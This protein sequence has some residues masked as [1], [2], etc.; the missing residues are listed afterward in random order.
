MEELCSGHAV[1]SSAP[2]VENLSC[3]HVKHYG[4]V[5]ETDR[6]RALYVP[7]KQSTQSLD[8][9]FAVEK[10]YFPVPHA[11]LSS[12]LSPP[13]IARKV[14]VCLSESLFKR[15]CTRWWCRLT[16]K[17]DAYVIFVLTPKGHFYPFSGGGGC[18]AKETRA[19]NVLGSRLKDPLGKGKFKTSYS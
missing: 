3:I 11:V 14:P 18:G 12:F 6:G 17:L 19:H 7:V 4:W 9:A 8:C 5:F 16:G 15:Q 2:F 1:H 10:V 13:L